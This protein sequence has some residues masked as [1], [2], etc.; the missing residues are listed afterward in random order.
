MACDLNFIVKSGGLFKVTGITGSHMHRKGDN[1]LE[2]VL[3]RGVVACCY[4]TRPLCI[5]KCDSGQAPGSV[6][7]RAGDA[8]PRANWYGS[9]VDRE[10][11]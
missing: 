1:I 5:G 3:D 4:N 8:L 6:E 11:K 7:A 2:T 9:E 10:S